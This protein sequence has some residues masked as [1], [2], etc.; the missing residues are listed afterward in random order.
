MLQARIESAIV[1]ALRAHDELRLSTLRLLAAAMH[2]REIEKRSRIA[3]G[4]EVILTDE[5]VQQ[6]IRSEQKKRRDAA[7]AYAAGGRPEAAAREEAEAAV[8]A[9]FLPAELSDE[10]I[11]AMV[12][13][14]MSALGITETSGFGRLMGWVMGRASGRASGERVSASVRKRLGG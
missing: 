4:D 6:A 8:L 3:P 1:E 14:G 9:E 2:N 12:G 7:G 10:E 13:E 11:D 5:E